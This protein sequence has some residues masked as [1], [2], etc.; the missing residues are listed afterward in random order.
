MTKENSHE[1][2]RSALNVMPGVHSVGGAVPPRP[3]RRPALQVA[4]YIE[5]IRAGSRAL[6]AQAI[7][8]VESNA[9][10]HQAMAQDIIR[11]L[12]PETGK[13]I[14][15]GITGVPGAGKSTLI[16]AL[17]TW[18]CER[19]KKVAVLAVDPSSTLTRGSILGDK[20]RMESLS[21]HPNAFIRPSPSGGTLGGVARKTKET[22][23]LC[24][25]FGFDTVI[26]ET[27]GVGQSEGLVRS[28][29]DFFLLVLISGAGD[30]LQ[31]IKKGVME[32][33]DAIVVNKADGDNVRRAR[34]TKA[35]L[36]RAL[37][38]LQ[39]AT[40]GWKTK[41]RMVSAITHA[42]LPELWEVVE[43][44]LQTTRLSGAF[45]RRRQ[46]QNIQWLYALIDEGI[47]ARF[48]RDPAVAERLPEIEKAVRS[49][50]SLATEAAEDLL[51]PLQDL[52]RRGQ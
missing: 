6:L 1:T 21:R 2:H 33:A 26:L 28:M 17:G 8:L 9:A 42:G 39:P 23:L 37:S 20:T 25:A 43:R 3:R 35:E 34:L 41:A 4:D 50:H 22:V 14:R 30:E 51:R 48:Y 16:E 12:M 45:E 49:G 31:G 46:H 7:T 29:V 10:H 13:S 19:E 24:E 47:R 52:E 36:N 38:F 44:F 18:L 27:V 32:L 40:E 5:G 11:E 15:L